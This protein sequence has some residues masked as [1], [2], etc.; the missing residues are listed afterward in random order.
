[1]GNLLRPMALLVLDE[2]RTRLEEEKKQLEA[3]KAAWKKL[4]K[5]LMASQV[6]SLKIEL[7]SLKNT[8]NVI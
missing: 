2:E 3:E 4:E 5:K 1:M 8:A 6:C 7:N